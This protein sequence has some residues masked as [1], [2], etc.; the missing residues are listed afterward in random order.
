MIVVVKTDTRR[1][2]FTAIAKKNGDLTW[3]RLEDSLAITP[4]MLAG[5]T[6]E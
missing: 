3:D 5:G 6:A 2:I 4:A 1:R